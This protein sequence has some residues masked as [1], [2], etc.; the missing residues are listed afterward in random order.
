VAA[1]GEPSRVR[2]ECSGDGAVAHEVLQLLLEHLD[3]YLP[4]AALAREAR[5]ELLRA[6]H[7]ELEQLLLRR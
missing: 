1:R 3:A 2:E 4:T 6:L 5:D 7:L